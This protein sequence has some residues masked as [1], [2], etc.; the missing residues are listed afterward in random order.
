MNTEITQHEPTVTMTPGEAGTK[1]G[2]AIAATAEYQA[3]STAEQCYQNDP[4]ARQLLGQYQDAQ[5]TLQLMRQLG[6]DTAEEAQQLEKLGQ[7]IEANG[8][9]KEYFNA[10]EKLVA[11]LRELNEFISERLNLDFAG[12]TKPKSGCCG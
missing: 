6:S 3:F 9:L 12:L 1:L 4:Q 8:T 11:L 5:Q 10:Q 2:A 7:E